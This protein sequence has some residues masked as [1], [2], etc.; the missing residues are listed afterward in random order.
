MA[1]FRKSEKP[2]SKGSLPPIYTS[3]DTTRTFDAR[4][5]PSDDRRREERVRPGQHVDQVG[6]PLDTVPGDLPDAD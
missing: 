3:A 2:Q 1:P 4:P 6:D 5:K